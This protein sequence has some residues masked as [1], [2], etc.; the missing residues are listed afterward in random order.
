MKT[1]G[2]PQQIRADLQYDLLGTEAVQ[3]HPGIFGGS[4]AAI[5]KSIVAIK[6]CPA[7]ECLQ[8]WA[9]GLSDDSSFT[10]SFVA[11]LFPRQPR[12]SLPLLG[13]SQSASLSCLP[14]NVGEP[15]RV[16][17]I[18]AG[19]VRS[20]SLRPFIYLSPEQINFPYGECVGKALVTFAID[21]CP[22]AVSFATVANTCTSS[23]S[24]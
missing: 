1:Y 18:T 8:L 12:V 21:S 4:R 5:P 14:L 17:H 9:H 22:N 24:M 7:G 13:H 16:F 10:V 3:R 2:R 20:C 19:L 23:R 6:S 11:Y 15:I